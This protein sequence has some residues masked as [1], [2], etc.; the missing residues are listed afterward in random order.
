MGFSQELYLSLRLVVLTN[1]FNT[2][3]R[4][5]LGVGVIFVVCLCQF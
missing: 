4:P 1:E 5:L 3:S 2:L